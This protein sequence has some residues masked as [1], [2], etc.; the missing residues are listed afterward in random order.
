MKG[1]VWRPSK[2][3]AEGTRIAAFMKKHRIKTYERLIERSAKDP[4]WF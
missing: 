1:I 2:K 4:G 3:F